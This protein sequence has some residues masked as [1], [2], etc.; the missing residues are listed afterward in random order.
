MN[1]AVTNTNVSSTKKSS[2]KR[3]LLALFAGA[4][5][6]IVCI[7]MCGKVYGKAE[8]KKI[9]EPCLI[10][11]THGS[12][13]DFL[14]GGTALFPKYYTGVIAEILFYKPFLG[15]LLKQF[16]FI[17]KKQFS[18]DVLCIKSIKQNIESGK[19]VFLCPEGKTSVDGRCGYI[20]PAVSKLIK[21][22]GVPVIL[23]NIRGSHLSFPRWNKRPRRGK[24][25]VETAVL[26]TKD[27]T[28]K[29]TNEE[30]HERLVKAFDYNDY[31]YQQKYKVK[32]RTNNTAKGLNRL[33]YKCPKCGKEFTIK[34]KRNTLVCSECG[35]SAIV[36]RYGNITA[37]DKD[38]IVFDRID[39]WADY[40]KED[41][42]KQ[43]Q[44]GGFCLT[45]KTIQ[46]RIN[47]ATH[48]PEKVAEGRLTLTAEGI[49]FTPQIIFDKDS[50]TDKDL[51][52]PMETL[53]TT[54]FYNTYI[55][56]GSNGSLCT[57]SFE[58][59]GV[60]YKWNYAVEALYANRKT[61]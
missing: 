28:E 14:Y 33:L 13:L 17:S 43:V 6:K 32:L 56:L 58:T 22:I 51:F 34:S 1:T 54:A 57:F 52:Y 40:E 35:N 39:R 50:K 48:R 38:S 41:I 21:W 47:S 31:D 60:A 42:K 53:P 24:V 37:A 55:I 4:L 9:K 3:K 2:L 45:E 61:I 5:F 44:S 15:K 25:R 18:V 26:F 8:L 49:A 11:S 20:P 16:G 19:N 27:E 7:F 29:L 12:T 23:L 36:D 59:E 10:L 46:H 30:I